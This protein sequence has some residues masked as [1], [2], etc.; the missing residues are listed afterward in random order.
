MCSVYVGRIRR[1]SVG[2]GCDNGLKRVWLR[3]F[4]SVVKVRMPNRRGAGLGARRT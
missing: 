1:R 4:Y 3:V 2:I